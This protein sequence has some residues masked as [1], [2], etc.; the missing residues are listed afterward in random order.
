M[1]LLVG[2]GNPGKGYAGNRHNFGYMAVD[3]IIRRHSFMP[4]RVRFQGLV[5][6]G[7]VGGTKVLALKPTT[8]MNLS[9]QSV[10]EA[11]RFYKIPIGNI[12]VLHDE[13]DLPLGKV[14]VKTGG[15]HGGNNGVRSIIDH[16]GAD[17]C[18]IRLGVGHPGEK[19][20][21]SGHVLKDFAKAEMS[22]VENIVDSV[23]R[24]A[25]LIVAG[26]A[27][28]FMNK[29]AIDIAPPKKDRAVKKEGN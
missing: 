28:S 14:R 29:I 20:L 19:H 25:E 16:I 1:I 23:A 4:E 21:V 17:F 26:D 11:A 9:G 6:E 22:M 8:Y 13:L 18:R 24:H 10:G 12:I 15:G 2:L 7:N 27:S 3:E 5:A